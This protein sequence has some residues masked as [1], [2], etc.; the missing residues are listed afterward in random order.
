MA[1]FE[2]TGPRH[3]VTES[4]RVD[5]VHP[6]A[7]LTKNLRAILVVLIAI[8][9]LFP[10]FVMLLTA[11]KSRSDVVAIPPKLIFEPTLE[12]FVFLLTERSQLSGTALEEA[13]ANADELGIFGRVA[14]QNGQ[15]ITGPSFVQWWPNR[16]TPTQLLSDAGH[17][18]YPTADVDDSEAVLTVRDHQDGPATVVPR[19]QWR[20][21]RVVDGQA[22]PSADHV[23]LEGGFQPGYVYEL[24]YTTVGAP[25]MSIAR[26]VPAAERTVMRLAPRASFAAARTRCSSF[27]SG[28][29]LSSAS[30]CS[31]E[32]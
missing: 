24:T 20:F 16:V 2:E 26:S 12:G 22:V 6:R 29:S 17:K 10:V 23:T 27:S 1:K 18:P 13:R 19:E 5:K 11:F 28:R 21:G 7:R 15:R 8:I 4:T 3:P 9:L 14:L 25:V 30:G 32:T 31:L